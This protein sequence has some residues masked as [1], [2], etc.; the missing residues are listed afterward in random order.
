MKD[1]VLITTRL[2]QLGWQRLFDASGQPGDLQ[3]GDLLV[4]VEEST[5]LDREGWA[6]RRDGAGVFTPRWLF[7]EWLT[8]RMRMVAS[9]TT[10]V[11]SVTSWSTL[12]V[13]FFGDEG[14]RP[15]QIRAPLLQQSLTHW[16]LRNQEAES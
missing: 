4:L 7:S 9:V 12:H 8:A 5:W 2:T 15:K 13:T 11:S 16:W 3:A 6:M 10:S 1:R 14:L